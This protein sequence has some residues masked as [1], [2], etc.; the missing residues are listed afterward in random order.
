MTEVITFRPIPDAMLDIAPIRLAVTMR[1]PSITVPSQYGGKGSLEILPTG[2]R[3]H[4]KSGE[5]WHIP[6]KE[7]RQL[8]LEMGQKRR[9]RLNAGPG[10]N[11]L[12]QSD[13]RQLWIAISDQGAE[14]NEVAA[15]IE[16][17]P[18]EVRSDF[19]PECGGTV[20]GD[21]CSN[22]GRS[23][24]SHSRRRGMGFVGVG[25]LTT[26]VSVIAFGISL[27]SSMFAP[28]QLGGILVGLALIGFGLVQ[29]MSGR[30]IQY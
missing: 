12:G 18:I 29:I 14:L 16:R 21:N 8:K 6:W 1:S 15:A 7:I 24:T 26:I 4:M 17:L 5:P 30:R 22:C 19:C 3:L 2:L 25:V 11:S 9:L 10:V 27:D 28:F 20:L 23:V 13:Y